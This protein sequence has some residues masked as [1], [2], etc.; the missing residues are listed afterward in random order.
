MTAFELSQEWSSYTSLTVLMVKDNSIE[1][2]WVSL[3]KVSFLLMKLK[4]VQISLTDN[5]YFLL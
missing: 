1:L 2:N 5:N 4:P 3:L